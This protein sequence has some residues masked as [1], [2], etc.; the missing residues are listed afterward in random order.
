MK[1]LNLTDEYISGKNTLQ[2][3]DDGKINININLKL[4]LLSIPVGVIL[5]TLIGLMIWS[6][7]EPLYS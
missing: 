4:L 3:I 7:L 5:L 1:V 2:M 6:T